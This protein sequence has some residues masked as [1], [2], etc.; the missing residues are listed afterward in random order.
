MRNMRS[1]N[2][3][4]EIVDEIVSEIVDG[5][6][7]AIVGELVGELALVNMSESVASKKLL[8]RAGNPLAERTSRGVGYTHAAIVQIPHRGLGFNWRTLALLHHADGATRPRR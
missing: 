7:G 4:S 5:I 3:L 6:V 2:M 1:C 8:R